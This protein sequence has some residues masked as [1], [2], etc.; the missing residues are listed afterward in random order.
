MAG[1]R[2]PVREGTS[3]VG[4]AECPAPVLASL[5]LRRGLALNEGEVDRE[6]VG[7]AHSAGPSAR[8]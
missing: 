3:D 7:R 4:V 1:R 5:D 8:P 2:A 6:H